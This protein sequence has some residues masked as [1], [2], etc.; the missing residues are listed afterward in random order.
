M[1]LEPRSP[2]S[3]QEAHLF[4]WLFCKA[5]HLKS[6]LIDSNESNKTFV[7]LFSNWKIKLILPR[8]SAPYCI[9]KSLSFSCSSVLIIHG[10]ERKQA[11]D[12]FY[13]IWMQKV[14][15]RPQLDLLSEEVTTASNAV[16]PF[17]SI[18]LMFVALFWT[19][20]L[21][22]FSFPIKKKWNKTSHVEVQ[23]VSSYLNIEL[24]FFAAT[25]K[26]VVPYLF[27]AFTL[28]PFLISTSTARWRPKR[29]NLLYLSHY[30][31]VVDVFLVL[32]NIWDV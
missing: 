27:A 3:S 15:M 11:N 6:K 29:M 19:N 8:Y 14:V 21:I 25:I 13:K 22:I 9:N 23:L 4:E 18:A 30:I 2:F 17:A 7:N 5:Q 20:S 10:W 26:A 31:W 24:P 28:A 16:W 12:F 32:Q 1:R